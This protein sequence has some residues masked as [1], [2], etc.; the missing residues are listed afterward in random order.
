M[1]GIDK[2][3]LDEIHYVIFLHKP[4]D[5]NTP[6]PAILN[7]CKIV[8]HPITADHMEFTKTAY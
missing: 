7:W 6:I 2:R 1:K 4:K 3:V 5:W 8:L